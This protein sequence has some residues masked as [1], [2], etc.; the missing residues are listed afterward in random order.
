MKV[1]G[2]IAPNTKNRKVASGELIPGTTGRSICPL[3]RRVQDA[4]L[5]RADTYLQS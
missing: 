5:S 1:R 2:G 3:D 4:A